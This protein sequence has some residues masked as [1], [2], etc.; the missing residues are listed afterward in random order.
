MK[1]CSSADLII[2]DRVWIS[3]QDAL[4]VAEKGFRIVQVPS[5]YFYLVSCRVLPT[6]T[7]CLIVQFRIVVRVD[8]WEATQLGPSSSYRSY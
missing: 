6:D 3:S 7:T 2:H 8:G 5:N 4:A 1:L